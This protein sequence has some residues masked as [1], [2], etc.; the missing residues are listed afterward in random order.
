LLAAQKVWCF[1]VKLTTT[2]RIKDDGGRSS[3]QQENSTKVFLSDRAN[4][5]FPSYNGIVKNEQSTLLEGG[6]VRKC[7]SGA[8]PSI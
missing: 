6:S 7:S 2:V 5:N 4:S 3:S 8:L 1:Y